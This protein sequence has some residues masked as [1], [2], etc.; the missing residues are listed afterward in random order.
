MNR[1]DLKL[2]P[3]DSYRRTVIA[4]AVHFYSLKASLRSVDEIEMASNDFRLYRGKRS[5]SFLFRNYPALLACMRERSQRA[6]ADHS[7]RQK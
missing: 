1:T 4:T 7:P 6:K 2:V 3:R 5:V